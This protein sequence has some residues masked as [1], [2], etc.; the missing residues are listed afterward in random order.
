MAFRN[1][2]SS[3]T[4]LDQFEVVSNFEI[5]TCFIDPFLSWIDTPCITSFFT[6]QNVKMSCLSDCV[7]EGVYSNTLK[8]WI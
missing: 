2:S 1:L 5:S 7:Y 3:E 6:V 4:G 8:R